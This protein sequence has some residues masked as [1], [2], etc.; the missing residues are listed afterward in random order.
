MIS[1]L[2]HDLHKRFSLKH[3]GEVNYFLGIEASV[4]PHCIKL[5]QS[6]Y[7][8]ELLQRTNLLDCKPCPTPSCPS[9]KLSQQDSAFFYHPSLYRSIVGALQ[10]LTMTRSDISFNV[11]KLSQ[12]LAHPTT[13]HWGAC[14]RV[15]RYLKG[16]L[17]SGLTF[18]PVSKFQ[19]QGFVDADFASSV[20]DRRSTTSYRIMLGTNLLSWCSKKQSVL[21]RSSTEAES[22]GCWQQLLRT[23]LGFRLCS[24]SYSFRL[25]NLRYSGVIIKGRLTGV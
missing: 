20:D 11:N 17:H 8:K 16:T 12:F 15:L 22:I 13:N 5:S 24:L 3:M 23:L 4:T 19:L 7:V 1:Q 10:Y 21:A 18:T 14:K 9:V 25:S 6:K 2:I